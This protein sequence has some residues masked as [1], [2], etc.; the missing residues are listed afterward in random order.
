MRGGPGAPSVGWL[1]RRPRMHG[2]GVGRVERLQDCFC[3]QCKSGAGTIRSASGP[4]ALAMAPRRLCASAAVTRRSNRPTISRWCAAQVFTRWRRGGDAREFNMKC[5]IL[6]DPRLN[7]LGRSAPHTGKTPTMPFRIF[8][9][10]PAS[11]T[12]AIARRYD[13]LTPKAGTALKGCDQLKMVLPPFI[14]FLKLS[15]RDESVSERVAHFL[16]GKI[17]ASQLPPE[18]QAL[19][20]TFDGHEYQS[21]KAEL[22]ELVRTHRYTT[23]IGGQIFGKKEP[24]QKTVAK[25]E[26]LATQLFGE[27]EVKPRDVWISTADVERV[28]RRLQKAQA[29]NFVLSIG[30][31]NV[32]DKTILDF[33][34]C[35]WFTSAAMRSA[36]GN[37]VSIMSNADDTASALASGLVTPESLRPTLS[38]E[39]VEEFR[40]KVDLVTMV[41]FHVPFDARAA[42]F[43]ALSKMVKSDGKVVI[44]TEFAEVRVDART[45]GAE[46]FAEVTAEVLEGYLPYGWKI[47]LERPIK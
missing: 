11:P 28:G 27:A 15:S 16:M 24:Q 34:G 19:G 44:A 35:N 42:V 14:A 31:A 1:A 3:A 47:T 29:D 36:G 32:K 39:V 20:E 4:A 43:G 18:L 45:Q 7:P 40:D 5:G 38:A 17:G 6:A 37:V 9:S 22:Y 33:A 2:M 23:G 10:V 25:L 12:Q 13:A 21:V 8:R 46:H 26:W 30:T 41:N